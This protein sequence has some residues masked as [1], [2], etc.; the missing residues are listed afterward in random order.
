MADEEAAGSR[1]R[2]VRL[3]AA[4]A[5]ITL[6]GVELALGWS[7]LQSAFTQLRAPHPGWLAAAVAA[8]LASMGAYARMQRRLLRSAGVRVSLLRHVGLA[9]AAHSLSVT[10]PGGPAFSTRF[11]Y[12]QLRRFGASPAVASWC[13]ALSGLLSAAALAGVSTVGAIAATGAAQW[14]TLAGLVVAALLI[15]LGVRQLT[16]HPQ[17]LDGV[18]CAVLAALNQIRR[19]PTPQGRDRVRGFVEQLRSTRL[20]PGHAVAAVALATANWLLDAVCLWMSFLAI[21]TGTISAGQLLLAYCAGMAAATIT[22]I[23]GGLGVI[24][25]ALILGLVAGGLDAGSAIATVV[26]YRIISFGFIIGAGWVSWMVIRYRTA[27]GPAAPPR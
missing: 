13:I 22:V 16:R 23:P 11:N 24:D 15:G 20:R 18:S 10:L 5:L 19:R 1:W 2:R 9:Y 26:L 8:E 12:E 14:H 4:A 17:A 27:L 7:S 6:F 21:G 3:G 25:S